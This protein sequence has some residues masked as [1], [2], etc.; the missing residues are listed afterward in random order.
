MRN[1]LK[2]LLGLVMVVVLSSCGYNRIDAGHAGIKVNLYGDD[3]GVD[4]VTE[5]TGAVWYNPFTTEVY[6]VPTFVQNVVYTKSDDKGS[7]DN[8]EFRVTTKNGLVVSFDVSMNYLTP[9]DSVVDIFKK[10]R[11]PV[12]EL[13]KGVIRNYLRKAFNTTA[14]EYT[15]SQLYENRNDFQAQSENKIKNILGKEGFK[16][17]QVVLLNEL[18]L[19][20]SVVANIEAKVNA[21]QM[22]L[23]KKEELQQATAD[24]QKMIAKARGDS[25]S[26]VIKAAGEA[27]AYKLKQ[28]NLTDNLIKQQFID[29]WDGKLPVY[30]EVPQLMRTVTK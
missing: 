26:S 2:V 3:K 25:A 16:I 21:T 4:D 27:E 1:S 23:R 11:K 30:G 22:A 19:P 24:A 18:R 5:V 9:K 13:E 29:K 17:E 10:Y 12:S 28:R 6:E 8:E 20:K 15:A 14:A 7:D